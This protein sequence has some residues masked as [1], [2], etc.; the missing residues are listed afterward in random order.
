MNGVDFQKIGDWNVEVLS[1]MYPNL[2]AI[3]S[4]ADGRLG[5]GTIYKASNFQYFG[6]HLTK[7]MENTRTG[8]FVHH[9]IFTN[10]TSTSG[11]LRANISYL[12]GDFKA[13]EVK[14]Y[15]YIYP[16]CRHFKFKT[17]PKP[18]PEYEKGM[19][20]IEWTRDTT[21]IKTKITYLLT[22]V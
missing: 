19:Q 22:K 16:L 14:T 1:G 20:P 7:F 18:Y 21:A 9:Q 4:F 17:A 3:Q 13:Y 6:Y 5:C 15:R 11:Y 10:S 2:V 8:E 12:I